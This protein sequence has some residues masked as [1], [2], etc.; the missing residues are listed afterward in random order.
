MRHFRAAPDHLHEGLRGVLTAQAVAAE[1]GYG[2]HAVLYRVWGPDGDALGSFITD[3]AASMTSAAHA[4]ESLIE[5][6]TL[7]RREGTSWDEAV[8]LLAEVELGRLAADDDGADFTAWLGLAPYA[9]A[10][11]LRGRWMEGGLQAARQSLAVVYAAALTMWGRRMR[12]GLTE[13]DLT[14]ALETTL[15]GFVIAHRLQ[16]DGFTPLDGAEPTVEGGRW[17]LWT[18]TAKAIFDTYTEPDPAPRTP[19]TG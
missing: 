16:G 14:V 17:S 3:V 18:L 9:F 8:R 1:A 11:P 2:S 10:G 13:M 12:P 5:G 15:D 19:S 6:A 4:P 7:L